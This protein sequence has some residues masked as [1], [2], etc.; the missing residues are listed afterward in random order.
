[1]ADENLKMWFYAIKVSVHTVPLLSIILHFALSRAVP[2]YSHCSYLFAYIGLLIPLN[3]LGTLSK[4]S[5]VYPFL[6]WV[7]PFETSLICIAIGFGLCLAHLLICTL[8]TSVFK[9][10]RPVYYKP[11]L[12]SK[13][14]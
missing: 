10:K 2:L 8:I 13:R 4:G 3:Y 14:H 1:M 7:N 5:P 6:T 11:K 12:G 9:K